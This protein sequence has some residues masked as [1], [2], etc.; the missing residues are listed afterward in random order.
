MLSPS[1][2]LSDIAALSYDV[3]TMTP[4]RRSV[5]FIQI[6]DLMRA[7]RAGYTVKELARQTGMSTRSIQRDLVVLQS[8][9]GLALVED[10]GRYSLMSQ[11]RLSPL[12]INLQEGRAL[13]IAVRLFLR[14]SDEGDPYAT[15]ALKRLAEIMP[16]SVRDQVR[17]AAESIAQRKIDPLFSRNMSTITEAWARRRVLRLLYRSAGKTRSKEV[18]VE[19]YFLEPSA[20]GFATYL[21]GYSRT[22]EQIRTFKIERVVAVEKLPQ[23]FEIPK[24]IDIDTLLSSAWGIIFGEGCIV[25]LRFAPDVTWR[26]KESRW[27]PS[28]QLE[29]LADGGCIL[30]V[31]VASLM[32]IGRW[33]R[34]WGDKAEV[35]A[36][37]ELREELRHEAVRLAR[38]YAA[39][40]QRAKRVR[41]GKDRSPGTRA[42]NVG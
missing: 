16:E 25:K 26:V 14:H 15:L 37:P 13:L 7:R 4:V 1:A 33:V 10:H 41:P 29:D 21:I 5:R 2:I 18:I 6:K 38:T 31:S 20:A 22:H 30:T 19:P 17:A 3:L 36:P 32:E 28:Q 35:L 11:E 42:A 23:T 34:S 9:D 8:E 39:P 40:A 27:H 12:E 24:D